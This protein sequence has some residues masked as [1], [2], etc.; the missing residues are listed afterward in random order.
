MSGQQQDY[1]LRQVDLL[2]QFVRR[3]L[4]KDPDRDLEEALLQAMHLQ[5]KLFP[6]PPAEFLRLDLAEQV[7][8]LRHNEP[9]ETGNAKCRTYAELLAETARLY[10][11]RGAG[12]HAD[13]ARQMAL[14]AAVSVVLDDPADD[15]AIG[16]AR[17]LLGQIDLT[18]LHPPVK[19]Q[20]DRL[21]EA[22]P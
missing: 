6:L 1:I 8:R 11:H 10:A 22:A 18:S 4:R 15:A 13:G 16:L 12:E 21:G 17:E 9:R 19:A 7:A 20:L 2:R 14:Y 3:V 5:E